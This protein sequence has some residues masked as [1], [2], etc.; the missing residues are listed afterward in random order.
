MT[1]D[2]ATERAELTPRQVFSTIVNDTVRNL[3]VA[4]VGTLFFWWFSGIWI[5]GAKIGFWMAAAFTAL[6]GVQAFVAAL[7]TVTLNLAG[8]QRPGE[9]WMIA[10]NGVQLA[11]EAAAIVLLLF[12]RSKIW[13]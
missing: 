3:I 10:A 2:S 4:G 8:K 11:G 5:L 12:L 13:G 7:L 6:A 9:G 1:M